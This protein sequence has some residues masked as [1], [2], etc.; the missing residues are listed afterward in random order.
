MNEKN[1][2]SLELNLK[3]DYG[4]CLTSCLYAYGSFN[5]G[6]SPW[7]LPDKRLDGFCCGK[8]KIPECLLEAE[9]QL[10]SSEPTTLLIKPAWLTEVKIKN[11]I[12]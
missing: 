6:N 12:L 9:P 1:N 7:N 8:E 3:F 11:K 4:T 10:F 5:P 2:A